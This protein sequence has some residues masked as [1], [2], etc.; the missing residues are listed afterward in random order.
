MYRSPGL[1]VRGFTRCVLSVAVVTV[2]GDVAVGG[3]VDGGL[4]GEAGVRHLLDLV[5]LVPVLSCAC[6]LER[7][8]RR[9]GPARG[10]GRGI[11][12]KADEYSELQRWKG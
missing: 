11:R 9:D 12:D 1:F 7:A 3:D 8:H 10:S 2:L 5:L 6:P 4:L